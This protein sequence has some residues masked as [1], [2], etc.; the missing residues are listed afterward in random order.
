MSLGHKFQ[1]DRVLGSD[2]ATR[3]LYV[4]WPKLCGLH[5]AEVLMYEYKIQMQMVNIFIVMLKQNETD[6]A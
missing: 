1:T 2:D 3:L 4:H 6:N 5:S